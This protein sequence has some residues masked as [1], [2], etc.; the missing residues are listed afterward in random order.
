MPRTP[1]FAEAPGAVAPALK[2]LQV[3]RTQTTRGS[4]R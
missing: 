3:E 1:E 2:I 4:N